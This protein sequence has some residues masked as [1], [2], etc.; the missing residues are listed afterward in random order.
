[1]KTAFPKMA[2]IS[3]DYAI[4]EKTKRIGMVRAD[5]Q[6]DDVGSYEA[7]TRIFA[8]DANHNFP[9][10]SQSQIFSHRAKGNIVKSNLKVALLGLDNCVIIE[11]DGI[12]LVAK[13]DALEDIKVIREIAG[14]ANQ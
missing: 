1:L 13:R 8:A 11:Q 3:I 14:E 10:G 2:N 6:W 4:M 5:F 7:L 12:L 9:I